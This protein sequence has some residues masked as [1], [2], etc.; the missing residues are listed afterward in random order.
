MN[1]VKSMLLLFF[2]IALAKGQI[3]YD[4][5][6]N[7]SEL[8]S[9]TVMGA[10]SNQYENINITYL[11]KLSDNGEPDLPSKLIQMIIPYD[12]DVSN[13]NISILS[14]EEVILNNKIFPDQDDFAFFEED[15][16]S[17]ENSF[18]APN[19]EIYE[20]DEPWPENIVKVRNHGF[21]DANNHIVNLQICPFRYL[22]KSNK[23]YLVTSLSFDLILE[24]N[25]EEYK[26]II[27]RSEKNKRFYKKIVKKL[28]VNCDDIEDFTKKPQNLSKISKIAS[29]QST[30]PYYEYV[31]ITSSAL[32]SSFNEFIDWKGRKGLDIGVVAIEDITNSSS[33]YTGDP[34]TP[35]LND[36]AGKLRQ[37]LMQGWQSGK[38]VYALLAGEPDKIPWRIGTGANEKPDSDH[39]YKIPSDL[40]F[41]SFAR[42]SSG[43][44]DNWDEDSD[45]KYGEPH[46]NI[47]YYPEIFVGRLIC[48]NSG[49][50]I[51]DIQRW[52]Q[53]LKRYEGAIYQ[54]NLNGYLNNQLLIQADQYQYSGENGPNAQF[55]KNLTLNYGISSSIIEES[56]SAIAPLDF[57]SSDPALNT[58]IPSAATVLGQL[59]SDYGLIGI[60]AH[61]TVYGF[62][63]RTGIIGGNYNRS[64]KESLYTMSPKWTDYYHG[65][66]LNLTKIN[67]PAIVFHNGCQ[68][69]AF[70]GCPWYNYDHWV[71]G[72]W[73][74]WRESIAYAFTMRDRR[75][76]AFLGHTRLGD[77]SRSICIVAN[78]LSYIYT[79]T[80]PFN[81]G[82]GCCGG[83]EDFIGITNGPTLIYESQNTIYKSHFFDDDESGTYCE[84]WDWKIM[85]LHE[86][87]IFVL[88]NADSL[89]GLNESEWGITIPTLP[90]KGYK[91]ERNDDKTIKGLCLV[92]SMDSD[93]FLQEDQIIVS[94]NDKDKVPPVITSVKSAVKS[95]QGV[96]SNNPDI[97]DQYHIGVA[98]FMGKAAFGD[99]YMALSHNLWGDPEMPVWTDVP[100]SFSGVN[101][102][103]GTSWITVEPKTSGST[104]CVKSKNSTGSYFDVRHNV[105]DHIEPF[106][107]INESDKPLYVT[108]TKPDFL[109]FLYTTSAS[110][111][112]PGT[113]KDA[114]LSDEI[115][116]LPQEYALSQNYPNPFN[117]E[118]TINFSLKED[119]KVELDIYNTLGQ[120]IKTLVNTFHPAG[121]HSVVW[122]GTNDL[123]CSV[124]SGIYIYKINTE[125]FVDIKKM[126]LIR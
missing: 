119:V 93:N 25:G 125:N 52:I 87:G 42:S 118:T 19:P 106:T 43:E 73:I 113:A 26:D 35:G 55:L 50:E 15:T 69:A 7:I 22:P 90:K 23:L 9:S 44:N 75:A 71:E 32:E 79:G 76:P 110:E 84:F 54:Y 91:W 109:P 53:T 37:Y 83:A 60:F 124:T 121:I 45:G 85:L 81:S 70:D 24:D 40:Y 120:K 1:F 65:Y 72:E 63:V 74:P 38:T 10:D 105:P 51:A 126:V 104:I 21:F 11:P 39:D 2:C 61:S 62:N 47:D 13:I 102:E 66:Q 111:Q 18:T 20:S 122:D 89:Y 112:N 36:N 59:N 78:I 28:V 30:L 4:V 98:E 56:P 80:A 88:A 64:A 12:K 107:N 29:V 82:D 96:T 115:Q 57:T 86:E 48:E 27:S 101:I 16:K 3:S 116:N 6:F 94:Y 41:S 49:D 14:E 17:V 67:K 99:H 97:T 103:E 100:S 8:S 92:K 58:P 108:I 123:G 46:D 31:I 114:E 33:G 68:Q 5:N 95:I 34:C 117:P 77:W